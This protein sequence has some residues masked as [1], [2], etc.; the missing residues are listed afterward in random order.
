MRVLVLG[1]TGAMGQP[2][3]KKLEDRGDE[4]YVTSRR[5]YP[6][7]KNV[8]YL[9]GDAHKEDFIKKVL[10]SDG[11]DAIVDFM[12]YSSTAFRERARIYLDSTNQYLFLSS[13]RVYANSKTPIKEDSPRLLDVCKDEDYL[14][15]DE[16]ALAKARAENILFQSGKR[17][18]TI[19]RPYITY[20]TTRL[21]LG[22]LELSSWLPRAINGGCMFL[23]KDI[24]THETT[25]TYG[26]NVAE[27]I[28]R[29]IGNSLAYGEAFHITGNE[30]MRWVDVAE[31]YCDAI[32]K[33]TGNRPK[34]YISENGN[35]VSE[36]IGN[37][38]Q[39]KYDRK[40]DRV[41]D[42]SKIINACNGNSVFYFISMETGLRK[43]I[44]EYINL[45][46]SLKMVSYNAKLE[47]WLDYTTGEQFSFKNIK[48]VKNKILYSGFYYAPGLFIRVKKIKDS[49]IK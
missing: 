37:I 40:Y 14:K 9:Q 43:C 11:F 32:E 42:N 47:G 35:T 34:I 39:I 23:P 46:Q 22:G 20:N 19:I 24:A 13:A 29:L 45:P 7:Q 2:L 4:V 15:T 44:E 49:R 5:K 31:I 1:G 17:N 10:S 36:I 38:W 6:S 12:V 26:E 8:H 41:F 16:Y 33:M 21:Q 3:I 27:A 28:V 48:G 18:W 25:M 30:H